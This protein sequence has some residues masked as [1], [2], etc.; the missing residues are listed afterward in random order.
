MVS[1]EEILDNDDVDADSSWMELMGKDLL[2]KVGSYHG[3]Q[4]NS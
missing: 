1:F 2:M 3:V 4:C